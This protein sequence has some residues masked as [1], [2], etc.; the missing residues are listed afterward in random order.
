MPGTA[1]RRLILAL[2]SGLLL[3]VLVAPAH[4]I[5]CDGIALDDGCLFTATGSDTAEPNDG[6]AVTNDNDVPMWAFVRGKSLQSL[7]YP[8][9]Q[10]WVEGP[11]T[12]QARAE[13]LEEL[14]KVEA[15]TGQSLVSDDEVDMIHSI[16]A[17]E[18]AG[19]SEAR[20]MHVREIRKGGR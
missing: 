2:V 1:M 20:S 12:L 13:I 8:I 16:W 10:R 11:F 15:A 18:I 3:L 14:R 17:D 7:G 9:S 19:Q 5:D 4:A 6:F